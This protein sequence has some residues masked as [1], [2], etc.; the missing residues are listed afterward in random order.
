MDLKRTGALLGLAALTTV[1]L[2]AC[3]DDNSGGDATS[4]QAVSDAECGGKPNLNASG[5]SSQNNAMTIFANSFSMSC[6]G[7]TLDYNSNGS[8]SGVK[9]FIGGQTDFGGSDSPLKDDEYTQAEERCEGPAWNLPAV[10]GPIAI[11]YNLDGVEVAL[12]AD[13]LAAIFKGEITN[14]N[15]PAIAE[16]NQGVELPDQDITVIFR[17]D[18]SGTTDNFQ[19]Y[20]EAAAPEVWT[21][22]A[23]K[24]FNGGTGE[25]SRGNEGVSAAVAQ[26]PGTITYTEWS[27]AK[28][29]DLG[30]VKVITP[31]DSEGVELNAETAGTT[32]DS[33]TLKNE[34]SNDLVI[35]TSSFYVPETAG[36]YPIIMPT[37]EIV[38]STYGDPEVAQA[39]KAFLNVAVS[40]DVQGQLEPEGYIPVPDEFREK[41]LTAISEI[42]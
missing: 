6:E 2:A 4:A 30:M 23:G 11:A 12:S 31:A 5:A 40:E 26:T 16:E 15:D 20:L 28:S 27:Y 39:V 9:E 19:K 21:E 29:Q 14:W 38:C 33:A 1:G 7:Q 3:S 32:I 22:G 37:Y 8:G 10:F 36:A 41:L 25:G 24:T 17:S 34:G 35:D 42:S 13:T 18:E